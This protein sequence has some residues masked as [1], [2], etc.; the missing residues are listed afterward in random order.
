MRNFE[1]VLK[2]VHPLK[3]CDP[4]KE[5]Y[6]GLGVICDGMVR[7]AQYLSLKIKDGAATR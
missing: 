1:L 5:P 4:Y 2:Q 7:D 3:K 6:Y